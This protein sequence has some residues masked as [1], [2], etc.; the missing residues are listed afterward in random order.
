MR[1]AAL[2]P[3]VCV[4]GLGCA[5]RVPPP[6]AILPLDT[7]ALAVESLEVAQ[8]TAERIVALAG[9]VGAFIGSDSELSDAVSEG[10][11]DRVADR[12][13][14]ASAACD[15]LIV[16][17][18]AGAVHAVWPEPCT[19][20]TGSV[21]T[22]DLTVIFSSD[23]NAVT[24]LLAATSDGFALNGFVG[25]TPQFWPVAWLISDF[26]GGEGIASVVLFDANVSVARDDAGVF[27]VDLPQVLV[28]EMPYDASIG[29]VGGRVCAVESRTTV[30]HDLGRRADQCSISLTGLDVGLLLGCARV[31]GEASP[32][33]GA[34]ELAVSPATPG[35]H[36]V[37]I[38][39]QVD[40]REQAHT[41]S[42]DLRPLGCR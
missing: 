40:R 8:E 7:D 31:E 24:V 32:V 16:R 18:Y 25:L 12:A 5:P 6:P 38:T 37:S 11:F 17:D 14:L 19:L 9:L 39:E 10:G 35:S 13:A 42:L 23:G 15:A 27:V 2:V 28:G 1:N 21:V 22:G 3:V 41:A 29:G 36:D 33:T 30:L 20:A 4:A 34:I 26:V